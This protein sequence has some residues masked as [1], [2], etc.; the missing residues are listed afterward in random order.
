MSAYCALARLQGVCYTK[1]DRSRRRGRQVGGSEAGIRQASSSFTGA[2]GDHVPSVGHRRVLDLRRW[3]IDGVYE[4]GGD[5]ERRDSS[6]LRIVLMRH[7]DSESASASTTDFERPV[8]A[9]GASKVQSIARSL[10][11]LGYIPNLFL[12]SNS[13]RSRQTHSLM[14]QAMP[15]L[16]GADAHFFGSLY[17]ESQLDGHTLPHL[18]ELIRDLGDVTR[19]SCVLCLG[20]NK[21]WEEAASALAGEKVALKNGDA[22][23][24][25]MD[26]GAHG[27]DREA[28]PM[29][30]WR[31]AMSR[32]GQKSGWRFKTLLTE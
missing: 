10:K 4:E 29:D 15:E 8:T 11:S 23:L 24:F 32:V 1:S 26:V 16:E 13:A 9:S 31:D 25:E 28:R 22:A 14:I 17:T 7:A 21:G 5:V 3:A 30:A 2:T 27:W 20:H 19:H 6:V 12:S 18:M